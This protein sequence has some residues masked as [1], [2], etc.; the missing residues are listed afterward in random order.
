MGSETGKKRVF[1]VSSALP[2]SVGGAGVRALRTAENLSD[3]FDIK[4]ITRTKSP[5][6]EL[7]FVSIATQSNNDLSLLSRIQ[8]YLVIFLVLPFHSFF[9]FSFLKKPD[10]IHCF[11]ISWLG[12]CIYWFNRIFWK[13]PIMYELTLM[14]SDTP[15]SKSKWWL[16]R[17]LSDYCINNADHINAISP[18]LYNHLVYDLDFDDSKVSLIT[19]SVDTER[20]KPVN[21]IEKL[22]LREALEVDKNTF[23]IVTVAMVTERKG[24][25]L[26]L[27][28]IKELPINFDFHWFFVGNFSTELQ[29]RL[30]KSI[31]KQLKQINKEENITFTA[32]V[33]PDKYLKIADLFVFASKRE[34][35]GTAVVEAMSSCLPVICKKIEGITDF[36]Y[37]DQVEGL[38]ID[39]TNPEVFSSSIIEMQKDINKRMRMGK[40]GRMRALKKFSLPKIIKQY[41]KLYIE[42]LIR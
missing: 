21:E 26:L 20:F 9:K 1:I 4:L 12:I 6:T 42:L 16:Y 24:Y 40:A 13:A 37:T 23:I 27:E 15:R 32:Y 39:S 10:L 18:L 3:S 5:D 19:N 34:G 41:E 31:T 22:Q 38:I 14:G 7:N 25:P 30:V 2:P 36:I 11:S 17:D 35:L 28:I 8:K 29:L 33:S